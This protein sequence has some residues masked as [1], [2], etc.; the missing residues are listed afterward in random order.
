MEIIKKCPEDWAASD[1]KLERNNVAVDL[2]TDRVK[3]GDGKKHWSELDYTPYIEF[4]NNNKPYVAPEFFG[5]LSRDVNGDDSG[6]IKKA[7]ATGY[8]IRFTPGVEY[9]ILNP[10]TVKS[11]TRIEGKGA[12]LKLSS[13]TELKTAFEVDNNTKNVV[14]EN[15]H[16]EA[17]DRGQLVDPNLT[18]ESEGIDETN[19][20]VTTLKYYCSNRE[21]INIYQATENILIQNCTFDKVAFCVRF[22]A[23]GKEGD[24]DKHKLRK[25]INIRGIWATEVSCFLDGGGATDGLFIDNI[26]VELEPTNKLF[27]AIYL[28]TRMKNL[29]ISNFYIKQSSLTQADK[30]DP[31]I[32]HYMRYGRPIS[33]YNDD[34][35]LEDPCSQ[36]IYISNGEIH[37]SSFLVSSDPYVIYADNINFINDVCDDLLGDMIYHSSESFGYY[38]NCNFENCYSIRNGV[39][40][41]CKFKLFDGCDKLFYIKGTKTSNTNVEKTIVKN[42]IID[43]N[44]SNDPNNPKKTFDFIYLKY[45]SDETGK[46]YSIEIDNCTVYNLAESPMGA[47]RVIYTSMSIKTHYK[48]CIT[49]CNFEHLFTADLYNQ[50]I[51]GEGSIDVTF[52]CSSFKSNASNFKRTPDTDNISKKYILCDLNN[53]SIV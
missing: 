41:N 23:H 29:K 49:D 6:I 9:K 47:N 28:R 20:S 1:P 38:T 45:D 21:C 15:L 31:N 13:T 3:F 22:K 33:I 5:E 37:A 40:D 14:F 53:I 30:D 16:F 27:H 17:S 8:N 43:L 42:S 35:V 51:T 24:N 48:L 12:I 18:T 7:I 52:K 2:D 32:T 36:P 10:I 4:A 46:D 34:N 26:H 39:F 50:T 11:N 19:K 44:C 25:N